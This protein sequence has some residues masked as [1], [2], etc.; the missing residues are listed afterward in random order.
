V[1]AVNVHFAAL[2]KLHLLWVVPAAGLLLWLSGRAARAAL[3]RFTA[4]EGRLVQLD[5]RRRLARKL[6]F[7]LALLAVT[8]ALLRPGWNPRPMVVRQE[9]RDVVFAVDVSHSMLAEDLA[10]N[11]LER[12][13]LA[14]L[15]TLPAVQGDRV[16][17]VAFAG[18]AAV[19]CPLTRD[20][21]FF[22]WAVEGLSTASVQVQGTLIGD[23]I[24]K[25]AADVFDPREKRFK[26]LILI[27]DG[28]DQGSYPE[29]A[30]S[31]AGEQGVRILAIGLGDEVKGSRIPV[32]G[33][34]GQRTYLAAGGGEVWTRLMPMTLRKMAL[35][36]PGGR[37]LHAATGTFDLGSLYR[38]LIEGEKGRDFGPVEIT[39]YQEKFQVFLL[40]ALLL[41]AAESLLP[42]RP[43]RRKAAEGRSQ[44]HPSPAEQEPS[45]SARG[46]SRAA[47]SRRR[48]A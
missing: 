34:G 26:D 25:I 36:T 41:L 16:A 15:D 32:E 48:A 9:G 1:A 14:I 21:G 47:A 38:G 24:R 27:S 6:L 23:A 19:V 8:G 35:A 42:E 44:E 12:A 46:P 45:G 29:V 2:D 18:E 5:R 7:L 17:V 28:E 4:L 30:A 31:V 13:K 39:R 11:R 40:A 33:E 37:Y 10:P 22:K 43:L 3:A 20:Y